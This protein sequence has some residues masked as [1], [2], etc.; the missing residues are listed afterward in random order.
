MT[1]RVVHTQMNGT[2]SKRIVGWMDG[3]LDGWIDG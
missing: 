2:S 3:W 1:E